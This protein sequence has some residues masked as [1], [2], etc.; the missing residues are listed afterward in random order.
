M[1]ILVVG[2]GGR[3]HALAWRLQQAGHDVCCAPG[4]GGTPN[5][6][7]VP[8]DDVAALVRLA[9]EE[10]VELVVVGPEVPLVAGLVDALEAAGVAAFGPRAACARLEGSKAFSKAAMLRWGVPT[11]EAVTVRSL[12]EGLAA[13]ERFARPPVVKASGLAAGKGVLVPEDR[14]GAEAALRTMFVERAFGDAAEEV[15]LEERLVGREVSVLALC[16]GTTYRLLVPAQDHKRLLDGDA[17]PN[18]GGMGAFAPSG[19]LPPALLAEVGDTMIA[20]ILTGMAA[21]GTP[22]VGILYAGVMLTDAGPKVLEYNCRFGDPEAQVILPLWDGD[23]AEAMV[24]AVQGRLHEVELRWKA[25]T[26]V[27]VVMAA[28]GYPDS[29]R[30]GDLIN[31][32]DAAA[33][34]GCT[35]FHAG[36]VA[37]PDGVRTAGGRVLAVTA[38]APGLDDAVATAYAGVDAIS[39]AGARFRRDIGRP[40]EGT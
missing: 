23:P 14:A 1:R 37:S 12:E 17:G 34:A 36:T 21:D 30:R 38:V 22:Y 31:G 9:V 6:R 20:P 27:T 16:S 24:A 4:N 8:A 11:A 35:V 10:A 13:L 28:E 33:D 29:P 5:N 26:A 2:G 3:E 18:T 32:L 19:T 15:V 40:S 25:A 39:F 7:P